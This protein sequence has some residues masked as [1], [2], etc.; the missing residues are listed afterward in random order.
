MPNA[1]VRIEIQTCG[2]EDSGCDC[3]VTGVRTG[4]VVALPEKATAKKAVASWTSVKTH[5]Q[6]LV[7]VASLE[8]MVSESQR[9]ASRSQAEAVSAAAQL[10]AQVRREYR[11]IGLAA[12]YAF[13]FPQAEAAE[14]REAAFEVERQE[15]KAQLAQQQEAQ[16][17]ADEQQRTQALSRSLT[18]L[19][20]LPL[21]AATARTS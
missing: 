6:L 8:A 2:E 21:P 17:L 18:A 3:K 14:K 19:L 16:R 5:E 15:K 12:R 13:P 11:C 7:K 4:G 10:K 1:Q 20:P 9:E